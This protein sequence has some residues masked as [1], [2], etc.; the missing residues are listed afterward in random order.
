MRLRFGHK[1]KPRTMPGHFI[2]LGEELSTKYLP[3]SSKDQYLATTGPP[4]R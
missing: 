1:K 4:K 3:Q 2:S